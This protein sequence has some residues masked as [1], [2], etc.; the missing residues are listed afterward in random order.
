[1]KNKKIKLHPI[2]VKDKSKNDLFKDETIVATG[3]GGTGESLRYYII[4]SSHQN[5]NL[6]HQNTIK[7]GLSVIYNKFQSLA[8]DVK[9]KENHA[10]IKILI[11]VHFSVDK[12]IIAL[13]KLCN[14]NSKFLRFHYFCTNVEKPS[15]KDIQEY[16]NELKDLN[17]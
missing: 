14:S 13:I 12:V 9:F 17:K 8:E 3:L 2:L 16:L 7:M 6:E 15:N 5:L 10:L 4:I 11:P 1:M